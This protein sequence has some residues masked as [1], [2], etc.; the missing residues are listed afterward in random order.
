MGEIRD[1]DE[2]ERVDLSYREDGSYLV[3]G[4]AA[5]EILEETLGV[6]LG[7]T[8]VTTMSGLVVGHLGKVPAAGEIIE[9]DGLS[10]EVIS[11]DRKKIQSMKVRKVQE[12][13]PTG[14]FPPLEPTQ[15]VRKSS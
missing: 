15:T 8:D 12:G 3:R 9:L 5:I 1:E 6:D 13:T 7:E 11:S 4:G 2:V 14:S 10:I